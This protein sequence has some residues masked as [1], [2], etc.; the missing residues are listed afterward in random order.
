[1]AIPLELDQI[2]RDFFAARSG[3]FDLSHAEGCGKYTEAWVRYAQAVGYPKVGHLKKN[4]S[5]TQYAGH[6][7]DAFLY[8]E[9]A[10]ETEPLLQA[11]DII[12]RAEAKPPYTS[13]NPAPAA[14]WGVDIPRYTEADWMENP[15][16]GG[17]GGG[18][19][20]NVV[21]WTA[22]NEQGF[23]ELKRQLAFDYGR[24]P[25]AADFDVTVWAARVFHSC[26]MGPSGTPLGMEAA[27][28][29]H[30][31][32]WCAALGVPVVPLP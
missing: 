30:R 6:A 27:L 5:Q 22:Y 10:S 11:V 17:E 9:P 29:K 25:Q 19:S 8:N 1:M 3:E 24:R 26:Y 15:G 32:E 4:P 13:A 20:D 31:P 23:E 2:H 14:N 28:L 21:P 7:I 18:E 12:A 16:D